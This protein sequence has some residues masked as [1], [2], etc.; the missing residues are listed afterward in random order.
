MSAAISSRWLWRR[1]NRCVVQ[2]ASV[3][4]DICSRQTDLVAKAVERRQQCVRLAG[5]CQVVMFFQFSAEWQVR[6][7][8]SQVPPALRLCIYGTNVTFPPSVYLMN[9]F[10]NYSFT[11][12][13]AR[14]GEVT[15]L[16]FSP[17][18]GRFR[19]FLVCCNRAQYIETL[20]V[21]KKENI[22]LH[23]NKKNL[24]T[25]FNWIGR[26]PWGF[27]WMSSSS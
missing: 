18:S 7:P 23:M 1:Q 10:R 14:W 21:C 20:K 24:T 15:N 12:T 26:H 22:S 25:T 8:P 17:N 4:D 16:L 19:V 11:P 9:D 2:N 13:F 6:T 3:N 5:S 27:L